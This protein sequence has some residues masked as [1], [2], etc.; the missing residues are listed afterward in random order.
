MATDTNTTETEEWRDVPGWEGVF[1]GSSLGRIKRLARPRNYGHCVKELPEEV[2]TGFISDTGYY[3][4]CAG[5]NRRVYAHQLICLAFHGLP[6]GD[7]LQVA[8]RDGNKLNNR[9]SNLRW[10]SYADNRAD[11]MRLGEIPIGES[12]SRAIL[13]EDDVRTI[14]VQYDGARGALSRLGRE[15]SLGRSH[16]RDIITRRIWKH[17]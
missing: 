12:H 8:H 5:R 13:T 16:V 1:R 17:I 15:W 14:R 4:I 7:K 3:R 6:T 10:A 9:P 11:G 2:I